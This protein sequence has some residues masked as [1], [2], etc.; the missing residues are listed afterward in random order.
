MPR[1][2]SDLEIR[3]YNAGYQAGHHDTVEG[4]FTDIFD[5]DRGEYHAEE[6]EAFIEEYTELGHEPRTAS[7]SWKR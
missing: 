6:V 7:E 2:P 3:L 4:W 5:C 1:K